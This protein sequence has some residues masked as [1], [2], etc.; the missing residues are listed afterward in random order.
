MQLK[1]GQ[2]QVRSSFFAVKVEI[3]ASPPQSEA[4]DNPVPAAV[5][6]HLRI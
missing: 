4:D 2:H 6:F 3:K 1:R 5:E